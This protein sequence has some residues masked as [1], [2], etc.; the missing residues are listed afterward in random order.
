MEKERLL[1]FLEKAAIEVRGLLP[2][3]SNYTFLVHLKD[4][5]LEGL[6]VYKPRAGETPL[7]D[8]PQ[9]TLCLREYAAYLVSE[10]LGWSLVPPTVLRDGPHGFGMVQLYVEADPEEHYF[11][12]RGRFV[13]Q[14]Q[15]VAAFD[16]VINNADRKS[17]HVLRDRQD[18]I[19]VIDHGVTF[20]AQYKLRTVIWDF[21]GQPIPEPILK[22]LSRLEEALATPTP[23]AEALSSL[24]TRPEVRAFR[25]RIR[26]LLQQRTFPH[27]GPGRHVPWPL[28]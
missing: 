12:M 5:A 7:W 27:P 26:H 22:D 23:L 9:G 15:R 18:R 17:G 6:A 14:F 28:V 3:S 1:Q 25:R 19:W 2:W 8:F 24:L 21:A 13:P 4:E 16:Y 20:H 11:T 10:A